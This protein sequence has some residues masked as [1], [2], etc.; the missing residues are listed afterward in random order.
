MEKTQILQ[1]V[2]LGNHVLKCDYYVCYKQ[3]L[4]CWISR[5]GPCVQMSDTYLN[6][7]FHFYDQERNI[8]NPM[9]TTKNQT[10]GT[11]AQPG[12]SGKE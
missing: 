1:K 12:E 7:K 10:L 9:S 3:C 4:L 8:L 5:L 11:R 2:V 6:Q